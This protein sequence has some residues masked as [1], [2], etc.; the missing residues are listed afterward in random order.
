MAL[1][2]YDG[3]SRTRTYQRLQVFLEAVPWRLPAAGKAVDTICARCGP[4][5][6]IFNV[7]GAE[8]IARQH[9]QHG[10]IG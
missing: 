2:V 5:F 7:D 1:D 4:Q 3:L 8:K 10:G 9:E 6:Q